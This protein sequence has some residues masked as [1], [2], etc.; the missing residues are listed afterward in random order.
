MRSSLPPRTRNETHRGALRAFHGLLDPKIVEAIQP[1]CWNAI[2]TEAFCGDWIWVDD[3]LLHSERDW[4]IRNRSLNR[5]I[6]LNVDLEPGAL[7]RLR[8]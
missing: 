7:L 5:F 8:R 1:D 3:E 6:R 4:M 2:K